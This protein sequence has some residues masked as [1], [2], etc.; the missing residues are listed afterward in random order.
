MSA[1]AHQE[2]PKWKYSAGASCIVKDADEEAALEGEWFDS[3]ADLVPSD[4]AAEKPKAKPGPK[5]KA[6]G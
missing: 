3:P 5:P 6:K 2:F 1:Y 4:D